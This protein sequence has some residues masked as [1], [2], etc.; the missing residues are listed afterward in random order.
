MGL[1]VSEPRCIVPQGDWCGEAA[2]WSADEGAIYWT[3]INRFLLHRHE[4][5]SGNTRSWFFT[6]PVVALSL[7]TDRT[8]LLIALASRLLL[9]R[10]SDDTREEQGT[11]LE[12]FPSARLNDGRS[13]PSGALWVGSMGNNVSEDGE[14]LEVPTGLGRLLSLRQGEKARQWR[15]GIDIANTMCWSPDRTVFYTGDTMANVLRA[16]DYNAETGAISGERPFFA[17]FDRG[18]PDG[19]AIDV[20]GYLWNCRYAGGCIVRVAPDGHVDRVIEMPVKNITTCTF[21]GP[22]LSTLLITTASNDRA[23]GDRLAGGLF[24]IDTNIRGVGENRFR[25]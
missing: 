2:T 16:Y 18:L 11:H 14:A 5:Q 9:W 21:G 7:T 10:P 13:D 3:D 12:D 20:A 1:E 22:E 23:R 25:L 6:E 15:D 24:A 4:L 8:R 19:S 17:G